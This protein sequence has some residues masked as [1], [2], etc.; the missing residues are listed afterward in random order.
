MTVLDDLAVG[1]ELETLRRLAAA[2]LDAEVIRGQLYQRYYDSEFN[3]L[4]LMSTEERQTFTAFLAESGANWCE[5]VVNALAERL[6]VVGFAFGGDSDLAWQLWKASA[7]NADSELVQTDALVTG[8]GVVL[9]QPDDDGDNPTGVELTAES[10]FECTVLYQPGDRRT[11]IAGYK[12]FAGL[13]SQ[14]Y[15]YPIWT[16][17]P[18]GSTTEVLITPQVVATWLAGSNEPVVLPNPA[19]IVGMVEIIPQ[20]RTAGPPRSEL[21]SVIPIQDRINTTIFSRLVASDYGAFRTIWATGVKLARQVMQ[22]TDQDG[23]TTDTVQYVAPYQIGA[24]RLLANENPQAHF[25][26]IPESTLQGYLA[27]VEQDVSQLAAITQTPAWYLMPIV[28]L[29]AD[30]IKAAESGLVAKAERRAKHIGEGWEQ[31]MRVALAMAGR[32]PLP[33]GEGDVIWADFETRSLSQLTDSLVKMRTLGVP[34][35][36]LWR[37]WGA[38]PAQITEWEQMRKDEAAEPQLV[39]APVPAPSTGRAN[40]PGPTEPVAPPAGPPEAP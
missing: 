34:I 37:R 40:F 18:L 8:R 38:T 29:A 15:P 32:P 33:K 35:K 25:G 23:V 6:R 24:N 22:V 20:P 28:N 26:A 1:A 5:L 39:P 27:S 14:L 10:P 13:D 12:R 21:A 7:M 30:A 4:A 36:E 2:K 3:I 9:V 11:A 16:G 19:G 31:V 17:E